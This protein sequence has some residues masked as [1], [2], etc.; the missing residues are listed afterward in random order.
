MGESLRKHSGGGK[1]SEMLAFFKL[2]KIRTYIFMSTFEIS[3]NCEN[4][5]II[6]DFAVAT[7][8]F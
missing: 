2:K 7:N 4:K 3:I 5:F 8:R 1:I 6:M